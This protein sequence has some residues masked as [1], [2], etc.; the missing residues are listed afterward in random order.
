MERMEM[1]VLA[2]QL[3]EEI[4]RELQ[5]LADLKG[6]DVVAEAQNAI[7]DHL[8]R[9]AGVRP[10]VVDLFTL[11]PHLRRTVMALMKLGGSAPLKDIV[12]T[13]GRPEEVEVE[14]LR[15][16]ELMRHIQEDRE[17]PE[18]RYVLTVSRATAILLDDLAHKYR[19]GP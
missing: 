15:R 9:E 1:K 10:S 7:V 17:A 3:P 4:L 18:P 14:A 19:V 8:R 13:T 11:P 12:K 5:L 2:V 6:V 16:L